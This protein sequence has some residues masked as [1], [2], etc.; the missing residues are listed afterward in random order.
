MSEH[1]LFELNNFVATITLNRPAK[2]NAVTSDMADAL[3]AHVHRCDR[4][5]Q[6]RVIVLTGAGD[7][8]FCAGSDISELDTYDTPWQFRNRP[9]YCDAIRGARKPVLCAINGLALGGGLET[10]MSCDIRIAASHARFGAPEVKLGWIGGGGMSYQLAHNIGASSASLM[11]MTGEPVT[12]EQALQ[13]GLVSE[14]CTPDALSLR[15]HE[16]AAVIAQRPPIA[17]QTAKVNMRAAY[18][19]PLETAIT[20]ER[21]LQ[22][23]C[24]A[25]DDACEGRAAFKERRAGQ[26]TGR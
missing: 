23:V 21:D 15:A 5:D 13:W 6:V 8:A 1:I 26:F 20:Y 9:D 16:L 19:M 3:V 25:T 24:F 17:V 11:L 22:T 12:A 2:L 14:L 4:D 7:K 18:A 10:A